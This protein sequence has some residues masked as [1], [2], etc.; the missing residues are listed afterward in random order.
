MSRGILRTV[1]DKARR[2]KLIVA[3][4]S[5]DRGW[6]GRPISMEL[7][8]PSHKARQCLQRNLW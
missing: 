6:V 5:Q 2:E 8:N 1:L 3:S 7:R 4:V